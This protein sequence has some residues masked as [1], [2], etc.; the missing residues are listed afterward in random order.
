MWLE[1]ILLELLIYAWPLTV[2]HRITEAAVKTL[3]VGDLEYIGPERHALINLYCGFPD[4][5]WACYGE[6]GGG[7]GDPGKPRFPDTRREWEISFYCLYD[8]ALGKGRFYFHGPPASYECAPIY[9]L[10]AVEALREGRLEDG[11][12]FLGVLL[13]YIQDSASFPYLQPIHRNTGRINDEDVRL[14][15]YIP[16]RLG[17]GIEEAA[18]G[19]SKRIERLVEKVEMN[20]K[21]LIKWAG[22]SLEEAKR[23]CERDVMHPKV[24]EAVER[25]LVEREADFRSVATR[26]A[27]ECAGACADVLYTALR[28]T[29]VSPPQISPNPLGVNLVFNPSFEEDDG[30]NIPDGWCVGW[31]DLDDRIGR[32]EWYR[33]GTHWEKHVR[34]GRRSALILWAPK[35]GIEWRQT[36]RKAI[37]VQEGERY[38]L[39]CWV[40]TRGA[41]GRSFAALEFYD[42]AYRPILRAESESVVGDTAWRKIEVESESPQGARWM[43]VILRSEDNK[44]AVWFDDVELCRY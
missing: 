1:F 2:H 13:H 33:M 24:V 18:D 14:N 9:F 32:A 34:T 35:K 43:R 4:M 17:K 40:E 7:T 31:L 28:F 23:L 15:S 3:P 36:W 21:P 44:G 19:V 6:W 41:T 12:R 22:L 5:N 30:D 29:A 16:R 38:K 42:G 11:V 37:R 27:V 26:C 39:S 8:P 25:I 10:K 20:M